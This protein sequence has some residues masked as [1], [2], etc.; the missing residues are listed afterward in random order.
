MR[1][2]NTTAAMD[3]LRP[4]PLRASQLAWVVGQFHARGSWVFSDREERR[5]FFRGIVD[6][7]DQR[8]PVRGVNFPHIPFPIAL[9]YSQ[10]Q[11]VSR[12]QEQLRR[13]SYLP[14]VTDILLKIVY[15]TFSAFGSGYTMADAISRLALWWIPA[16]EPPVVDMASFFPLGSTI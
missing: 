11:E 12:V 5:E 10:Q 6:E 8:W 15:S 9:D 4:F 1:S 13:V 2:R 3:H 7:F 16:R 14:C